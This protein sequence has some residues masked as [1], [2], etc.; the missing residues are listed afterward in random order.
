MKENQKNN[1]SVLIAFVV[2]LEECL[3]NIVMI[4]YDMN[5]LTIIDIPF[6]IPQPI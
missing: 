1:E 2:N 6:V 3:K 5:A 4:L